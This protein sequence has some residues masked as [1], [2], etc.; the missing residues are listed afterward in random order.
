MVG[1]DIYGAD[2]GYHLLPKRPLSKSA[3]AALGWLLFLLWVE[4]V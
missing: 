4:G 2:G 3:M 1:A